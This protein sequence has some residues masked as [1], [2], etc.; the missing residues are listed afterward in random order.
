MKYRTGDKV[1]FL[2]D[3]GEG[4]VSSIIDK[5]TVMVR[6]EDGFDIPVL[7]KDLVIYGKEENARLSGN[8]EPAREEKVTEPE[9]DQLQSQPSDPDEPIEDE[10][11][12]FGM[13]LSQNGTDIFSYLVNSSSYH[14]YYTV[15]R[16]I[17]GEENLLARGILEADTKVLVSKLVPPNMNDE[18]ELNINLLFWNNSFYKYVK[19]VSHKLVVDFQN[20]YS[21][22]LL[23]ENDYFEQ[24][25]AIYTIYSFQE[26]ASENFENRK[27][28]E[29]LKA[30]IAEKERKEKPH[31]AQKAQRKPDMEEV[32]LH[33][34][35]IVDD[36]RGLSNSEILDIQMSRFKTTLETAMIHNT[37]RIVFIHGIGNG[38]LKHE[39]RKTLERKY[40]DL[41]YQDASFKEYGYGATMVII[42]NSKKR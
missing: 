11:V 5:K 4:V 8:E 19:P 20:I 38:K 40:P 36:Y 34:Q 42:P 14:L 12:V 30:V 24:K 6:T 3:K 16:K 18:W 13:H 28:E 2:H 7:E 23:S 27:V 29:N 37:P 10:E 1:K 31:R 33:I 21:G 25:A 17:S 9:S 32:D 22:F 35:N 41:K 15:S 39:L 26:K